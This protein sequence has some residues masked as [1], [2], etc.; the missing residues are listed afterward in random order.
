MHRSLFERVVETQS[1]VRCMRDQAPR[2]RLVFFSDRGVKRSVVVHRILVGV[3]LFGG[4]DSPNDMQVSVFTADLAGGESLFVFQRSICSCVDRHRNHA[5]PALAQPRRIIGSC[6]RS[7]RDSRPLRVAILPPALCHQARHR[8]TRSRRCRSSRPLVTS[9]CRIHLLRPR[10]ASTYCVNRG[11]CLDQHFHPSPC[12]KAAASWS[13]VS[14][15]L[16]VGIG[17]GIQDDLYGFVRSI[18]IV[19]CR[20][21]EEAATPNRDRLCSHRRRER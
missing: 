6:F 13:G 14:P 15:S 4:I 3:A 1:L 16:C 18:I 11:S 21:T 7:R 19:S 12:P 10:V 17:T 9:A 2:P 20:N 5:V 8:P